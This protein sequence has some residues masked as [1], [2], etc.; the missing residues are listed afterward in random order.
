MNN[1]IQLLPFTEDPT[2]PVQ[3][4]HV[5][6]QNT[7]DGALDVCFSVLG[8][9]ASIKLPLRTVP[10]RTDGLW[11]STCFEMF[12]RNMAD[13]GYCEFN[14]SPSS[15]WAVYHFQNY[16]N[17]MLAVEMPSEPE[18][19]L[20]RHDAGFG[21]HVRV[22]LPAGLCEAALEANFTAVI[23]TRDGMRSYWA[24]K[25]AGEKPDF[26]DPGCFVVALKAGEAS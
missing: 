11:H 26:H 8:E 6:F 20:E 12:L 22:Q 24:I 4:M 3:A 17:G 23:E 13:D 7:A 10:A 2:C 16:R 19:R 9:A 18:I 1:M 5:S 15:L 14:F 25:H 21:L